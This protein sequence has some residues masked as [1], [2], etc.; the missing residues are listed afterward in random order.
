MGHEE[1]LWASVPYSYAEPTRRRHAERIAEDIA[2]RVGERADPVSYAHQLTAAA[3]HSALARLG[4]IGAPTLVVHGDQDAIVPSANASLLADAI[5]AAELELRRDSGHLYSTDD[6]RVEGRIERFL[7]RHSPEVS[8][9]AVG[10]ARLL[11]RLERAA[12]AARQALRSAILGRVDR[13]T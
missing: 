4:E 10:V 6:P 1:A 12:G 9:P 2:R 3:T 8:G 5:P 13:V 7:L 11:S